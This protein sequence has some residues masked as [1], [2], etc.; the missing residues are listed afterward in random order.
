MAPRPTKVYTPLMRFEKYLF[1]IED[2]RLPFPATYRQIGIFLSTMG[3]VWVLGQLPLLSTLI[4]GKFIVVS[5]LV[6]PWA[7][8]WYF[9][10]MNIDGK[11]PLIF[12]IDMISYQ[13]SKG[14]YSRYKRLEKPD[15]YKYTTPITYR[16]G[17][18]Q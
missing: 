12:V 6:V 8:M 11:P 17:E 13:F 2:V 14:T 10:K 9:T 5:Y 4:N 3:I 1:S 16:K 7:A 18:K 15:Q